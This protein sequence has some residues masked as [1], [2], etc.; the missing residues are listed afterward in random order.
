MTAFAGQSKGKSFEFIFEI[1]C[2][3]E[4]YFME[5]KYFLLKN[6]LYLN[7]VAWNFYKADSVQ[8]PL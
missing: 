4:K 3:L 6:I 8:I 1:N 7:L 5:K 2:L